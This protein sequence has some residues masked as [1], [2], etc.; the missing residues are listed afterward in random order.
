VLRHAHG[1]ENA[2]AFGLR[3]HVRNLGQRFD[4]KAAPLAGHFQRERLQALL[5]LR[6]AVDPL[7]DEFLVGQSVV[8]D[9]LGHRGEPDKIGAGPRM[10]EHI[11]ALRHLVLA[12]VGDDQLLAVH[13]VARLTRVASTGWLSA[14]LLPMISTRPACSMS[15]IDPE[16]PP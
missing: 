16:S 5:V 7:I 2:D 6:S 11:R 1:P 10:Q 13:L 8:E 9:V 15:V 14:V 12:Q 4:R 3:D